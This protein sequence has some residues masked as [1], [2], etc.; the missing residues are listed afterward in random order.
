MDDYISALTA[1]GKFIKP[2]KRKW[3][4]WKFL[5][6]VYAF[7]AQSSPVL[8]VKCIKHWTSTKQQRHNF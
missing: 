3:E 7:F 1:D 8:K 5:A 4:S 2:N 6:S